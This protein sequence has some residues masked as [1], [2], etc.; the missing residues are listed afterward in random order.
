MKTQLKVSRGLLVGLLM[1]GVFSGLAGLG[2]VTRTQAHNLVTHPAA[3]RNQADKTPADYGLPYEDVTVTAVDGSTAVGWY[4]PTQTGAVVIAQHG[5]KADRDEMLNEAAMLQGHGYGVLITSVRAHDG[6][7]GEMITFGRGEMLDLDAWY[8]FLL[9]RPEVDPDRIGALGNSMGGM[10][11]IQYAARNPAIRAVVANSAF[12]SLNDTVATSVT[13]FTGLPPF[14]FA[15]LIVWWAE[16]ETG[17]RAADI[18]TTV[19]IRALSPRPVFLMQGGA[20]IIVNADSGQRLYAAAGEPKELWFEP[21]LGHT[22]FDTAR[23]AEYER[24]VTG[25]FDQYLAAP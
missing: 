14:P 19:W 8:Q 16:R 3:T 1:I 15:P 18:D 23:P 13:Y 10:L 11:V 22:Q 25:F 6:S 24:R 9:S 7:A 12:S 21:D 20:D 4:V 5:Y 17:V 2:Y